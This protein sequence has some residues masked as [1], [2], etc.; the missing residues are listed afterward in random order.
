M[1]DTDIQRRLTKRLL[2]LYVAIF[3]QSFVFWYTIE[4]LFMRGIGFDD[5]GVG[6]MI[7]MYSAVILLVETP[8]GILA[9]RWSRKGVLAIGSGLLLISTFINGISHH[10]STYLVGSICWGAF[11]AMYSGTYESIVYD[12]VYEEASSSRSFEKFFGRVRLSE[13]LA[14][15]ISSLLG[16]LL[17]SQFGLRFNYYATLP[18]VGLSLVAIAFFREPQLH[19]KAVLDPIIKH[20]ATTLR[21]VTRQRTLLP[22]LAVLILTSVIM[23]LTFEFNQVWVIALAAP[24]YA[25][26]PANALM[27]SSLGIGGFLVNVI[28]LHRFIVTLGCTLLMVSMSLLLVF[29]RLLI[30]TVLAQTILVILVVAFSVIFNRLLHDTLSPHVRAGA[31]SA[32]STFGRLIIIP[33]ALLFGYISRQDSIFQA[34]WVLVGITVLS[35][36]IILNVARKNNY[37]GLAPASEEAS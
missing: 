23:Y 28:R 14:L 13:S 26:G 30:L 15:V 6:L 25:F 24:L 16:G 8:S 33:L 34:S 22:I 7:A 9:D 3:L 32:V 2:P 21:A 37:Q 12:T 27:L 29:S 10:P 4:K 36:L 35:C 18:F 17:A 11:F 19:K 20:T 5:A 31:A 1:P